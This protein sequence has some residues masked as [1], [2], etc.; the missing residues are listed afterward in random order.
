MKRLLPASRTRIRMTGFVG[1]SHNLTIYCAYGGSQY[2]GS[3]D[4]SSSLRHVVIGGG[5][6]GILLT[7][8]LILKGCRVILIERGN[9]DLKAN[10]KP[11]FWTYLCNDEDK[12]QAFHSTAQPQLYNRS[13]KYPVGIGLGGTS[14]INAMLHDIGHRDVFDRYWAKDWNSDTILQYEQILDEIVPCSKI[15][16]FGGFKEMIEAVPNLP[17]HQLFDRSEGRWT[18]R[19]LLKEEW[20]TQGRLTI[21]Q[22]E[23]KHIHIEDNVALSVI[24]SNHEEVCPSNGG[25]IILCAGTFATPQILFR[26]GIRS[27]H[28][29]S[30][31]NNNTIKV[32]DIGENLQDHPILGT[33][34]YWQ[35][36]WPSAEPLPPNCVH[37]AVYL[38]EKGDFLDPKASSTTVP[39]CQLLFMD[40]RLA[41]GLVD[42]I[43]PNFPK[44][45]YY[46]IYLRPIIV[47][48]LEVFDLFRGSFNRLIF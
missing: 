46:N 2:F 47:S 12:A 8:Q 39:R 36:R 13:I 37:G 31:N 40:G 20:V 25:E 44:I 19:S 18:H 23:V 43:V 42:I 9:I 3:M 17:P 24:L 4:E 45:T 7:Y 38:N 41:G 6:A 16:T 21:R 15:E 28:H 32:V 34:F 14:N 29:S 26:S 22:S 35:R 5:T 48:L 33:F 10:S 1:N 11:N 30:N 27:V